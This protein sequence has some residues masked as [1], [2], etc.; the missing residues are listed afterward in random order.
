MSQIGPLKTQDY[1]QMELC[2]EG[3]GD[4]ISGCNMMV[5][6][7]RQLSVKKKKKSFVVSLDRKLENGGSHVSLGS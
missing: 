4:T 6:E 5:L 1:Q 3:C 7:V 2:K